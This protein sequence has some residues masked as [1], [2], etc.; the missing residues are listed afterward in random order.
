MLCKAWE[1]VHEFEHPKLSVLRHVIGRGV[2]LCF[3][4][5]SIEVEV[6]LATSEPRKRIPRAII[7]REI[8]AEIAVLNYASVIYCFLPIMGLWGGLPRRLQPSDTWSGLSLGGI[9]L[10][11]PPFTYGKGHKWIISTTTFIKE[12]IKVLKP[13]HERSRGDEQGCR[14]KTWPPLRE[15]VS[16]AALSRPVANIQ[17]LPLKG[18]GAR[19]ARGGASKCVVVVIIIINHRVLEEGRHK[20]GTTPAADL[21]AGTPEQYHQVDKSDSTPV[22]LTCEDVEQ[23]I[24][25]DIEG[26]STMQHGVQNPRTRIDGKMEQQKSNINDHASQHLLSLLQKRTKKE[27]SVSTFRFETLIGVSFMKEFQS[28]QAPVSTQRVLDSGANAM[29]LPTSVGFLFPNSDA[30]FFSSSS[31]DHQPN[32]TIQEKNSVTSNHIHDA[33]LRYI[34]GPDKEHENSFVEEQKLGVAGFVDRA[35]QIHL[36]NEDTLIIGSDAL[37]SVNSDP[38]SFVSSSRTEGLFS[39]RSMDQLNGKL[40]NDIPRNAEHVEPSILD[41]LPSFQNSHGLINSGNFYH[42]FQGTS[43]QLPHLIDHARSLHTGL[44]HLTY[45]NQQMK[46]I[47]LEGINH[48]PRQNFHGNVVP[49]NSSDHANGP[50]VHPSAYHLIS[51]QM[52]IPGN[53]PQQLPLPGYPRGVPL[54]HLINHI[55]P[56]VAEVNNIQNGSLHHQQPNYGGFGVGLPGGGNHTEVFQRLMEMEMRANAKHVRPAAAGHIPCTYGPEFGMNFRYR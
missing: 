47:G 35:P 16:R 48:D 51:T 43:S 50:H 44:D 20:F 34:L 7:A 49:R 19:F 9:L 41:G 53:L 5:N 39:Q 13:P 6:M 8:K 24:L 52:P 26:S 29:V 55:P 21:I 3:F 12:E 23:P 30:S 14:S 54:S 37:E 28:A 42:R 15:E 17:Q 40:L 46:L 33:N 11:S 18:Q 27:E 25:V 38:L 32:M 31:G 10:M 1:V 2:H 4:S 45:R 56:F 22:P 36:P